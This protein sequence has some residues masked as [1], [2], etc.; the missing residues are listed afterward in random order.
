MQL[1]TNDDVFSV[2]VYKNGQVNTYPTNLSIYDLNNRNMI[3]GLAKDISEKQNYFPE[4]F[5]VIKS[6]IYIE[7]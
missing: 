6:V 1:E 7:E 2:V 5:R 3:N 4:K